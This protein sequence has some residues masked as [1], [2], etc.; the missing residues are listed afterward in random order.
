MDTTTLA[1]AARHIAGVI[2]EYSGGVVDTWPIRS[3]TE[4]RVPCPRVLA[5]A[6]VL[7]HWLM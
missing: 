2:G 5:A 1:R 6:A 7:R 4:D 3:H